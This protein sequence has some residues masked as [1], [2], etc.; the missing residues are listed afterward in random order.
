MERHFPITGR[1]NNEHDAATSNVVVA[2]LK[3]GN[4]E[5]LRS[6]RSKTKRDQEIQNRSGSKYGRQEAAGGESMNR[7]FGNMGLTMKGGTRQT[8][9]APD[10]GSFRQA[11]P[12]LPNSEIESSDNA[13][14]ARDAR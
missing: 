5:I 7:F 1:S 6:E 12:K 11:F 2:P 9:Q 10:I 3:S 13:L 8:P 4:K 14:P